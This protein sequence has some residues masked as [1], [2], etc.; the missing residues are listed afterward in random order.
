MVLDKQSQALLKEMKEQNLPPVNTVSPKESRQ[1]FD[2]RPRLPGPKVPK[3]RYLS[4]P[5]NGVNINCRM[6]IPDTKK[7][8]PILVWFHGGGFNLLVCN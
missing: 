2:L 8:L 1:Q 6:Y 3:V 7:K 4:V 5:V